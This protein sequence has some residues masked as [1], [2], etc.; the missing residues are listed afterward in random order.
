MKIYWL[1][2]A[3]PLCSLGGTAS[4]DRGMIKKGISKGHNIEIITPNLINLKSITDPDLV[5]LSNIT[6]FPKDYIEKVVDNYI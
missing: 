5:I 6:Q 1:N 3:C 4:N 2:D